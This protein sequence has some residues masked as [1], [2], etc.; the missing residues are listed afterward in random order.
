[1]EILNRV[2]NYLLPDNL[3]IH[4]YQGRVHVSGFTTIGEI[5]SEKIIIRHCDGNFI[6]KGEKL[7]LSKLCG[8]EVLIRGVV[9]QIEFR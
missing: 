9:T 4:I 3:E 7:V 5:S 1:M 8:D 6:I 2:R